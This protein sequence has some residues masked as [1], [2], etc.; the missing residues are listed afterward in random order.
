MPGTRA[1]TMGAPEPASRGTESACP[2]HKAAVVASVRVVLHVHVQQTDVGRVTSQRHAKLLLYVLLAKQRSDC[3]RV[4]RITAIAATQTRADEPNVTVHPA[5]RGHAMYVAA[6]PPRAPW[7]LSIWAQ[8]CNCVRA[9]A[10]VCVAGGCER[11]FRGEL[12]SLTPERGCVVPGWGLPLPESPLLA[13]HLDQLVDLIDADVDVRQQVDNL[14]GLMV[15]WGVVARP[16]LRV[17]ERGDE[18]ARGLAIERLVVRIRM[19]EQSPSQEGC[20]GQRHR[21]AR[22]TQPP[23]S[24]GTK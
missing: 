16:R 21:M 15:D 9:R 22:T 23:L 24:L 13:V 17:P 1:A 20:I 8:D 10:C 12:R 19:P 5:D 7:H 14:A 2:L 6:M 3:G 11:D 18:R 4:G